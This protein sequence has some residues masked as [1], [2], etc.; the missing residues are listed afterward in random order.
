MVVKELWKMQH[1][2][3]CYCE[4][5]IPENG[6]AKAVEHF[7]PQSVFRAKRNH[8]TNLLLA[9]AQC[10]GKKSDKFPVMLTDDPHDIKIVY[11]R[12]SRKGTPALINPAGKTDPEKHLSYHVALGDGPLAGQI[13]ARQNSHRG[14][15]TISTVGLNQAFYHAQRREHFITLLQLFAILLGAAG[16]PERMNV[17]RIQWENALSSDAKFAGLAREFARTARLDSKFDVPVPEIDDAS[18]TPGV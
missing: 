2:K 4:Q 17:I 7:H 15:A 13:R 10:N 18:A 5:P 16:N 6:H 14:Q 11:V 3:C 1:G 12:H 9:C 8:W